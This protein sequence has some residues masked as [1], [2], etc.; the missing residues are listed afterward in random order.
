MKNLEK[1]ASGMAPH[2]FI[3]IY[4]HFTSLIVSGNVRTAYDAVIQNIRYPVLC[5]KTCTLRGTMDFPQ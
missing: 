4:N 2:N 1:Y 3:L 5:L